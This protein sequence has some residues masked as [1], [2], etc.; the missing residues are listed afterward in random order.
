MVLGGKKRYFCQG[1]NAASR[2]NFTQIRRKSLEKAAKRRFKSQGWPASRQRAQCSMPEQEV[3]YGLWQDVVVGV[4]SSV[5]TF[6]EE[7]MF[8]SSFVCYLAGLRKNYRLFN[9]KTCWKMW[10]VD[11]DKGSDPGFTFSN[12]LTMPDLTFSPIIIHRILDKKKTHL[13]SAPFRWRVSYS[14][15][16]EDITWQAPENVLSLWHV[17]YSPSGLGQ[18]IIWSPEQV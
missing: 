16:R 6:T 5:F 2:H 15:Q 1:Q 3:V 8:S 18:E 4:P 7:I 13:I 17:W 12:S 10:Y 14:R 11:P 9:M